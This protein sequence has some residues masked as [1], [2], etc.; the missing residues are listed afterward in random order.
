[1]TVKLYNKTFLPILLSSPMANNIISNNEEEKEH[2]EC[3]L[4]EKKHC[5]KNFM[6]LFNSF[7]N[8]MR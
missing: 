2:F 1:M 6:I 4:C 7:S 5:A 8:P 3:S